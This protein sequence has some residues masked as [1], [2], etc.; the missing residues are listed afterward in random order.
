MAYGYKDIKS[1]LR[2]S[3]AVPLMEII[4]R[5]DALAG[6]RNEAL[7]P[8]FLTALKRVNNITPDAELPEVNPDLFSQDEERVLFAAYSSVRSDISA[9]I[10][11]SD[12]PAALASLARLTP[13]INRFFDKVLVMDKGERVKQNRLSLLQSIWNTA[14]KIADLSKLQ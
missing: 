14:L 2:E 9:G 6:F 11:S 4:G 13:A 7:F 10:G 12:Y 8:E 3:C 1:M 5:M